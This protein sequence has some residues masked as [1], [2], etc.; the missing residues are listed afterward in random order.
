ML[1]RSC[2]G[3]WELGGQPSYRPDCGGGDGGIEEPGGADDGTWSGGEKAQSWRPCSEILS[4][5]AG[6]QISSP[7]SSTMTAARSPQ[8]Q[9]AQH[10]QLLSDFLLC[11]DP[12]AL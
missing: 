2:S 11:R 10:P 9:K 1:L 12:L 6:L 5:L 4:G 7:V 8:G 3:C